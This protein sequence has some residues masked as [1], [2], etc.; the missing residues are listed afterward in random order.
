MPDF[1][2]YTSSDGTVSKYAHEDGSETAIKLPLSVQSVLNPLTRQI[3]VHS[4]DR[5]KFSVFISAS[6]G[7]YM[8]CPFC[9]LTL[10]NARYRPLT[11]DG[12]LANLKEA[13]LHKLQETPELRSKYI[14][15][16]W[17]GMG[18][19]VN[20]PGLVVDVT[21]AFLDWVMENGFAKG[22]DGVDLSTV[23]PPVNPDWVTQFQSLDAMLA[24]YPSNPVHA[25]DNVAYS[26]GEYRRRTPFRLFY[27]VHSA[28]QVG[29]D[30][31]V[32][33][34]LPL[35]LAIPLL[36]QF[37]SGGSHTLVLHHL[38]VDG[39]N[40]SE[41]ELV[42]LA[43]LVNLSFPKQ[44]LRLLRYNFCAKSCYKESETFLRQAQWLSDNVPFLKV[45][46][47]PGAEVSA[48]CGQFIVKLMAKPKARS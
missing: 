10:K 34:A 37:V 17:M 3:D 2:V 19:A 8:R 36:Q 13:L 30:K 42:A 46:V 26:S 48:A 14:K 18:D 24:K 16:S 28:I 20:Q 15:L 39:L 33:G 7:C 44:E 31:T 40:D 21:L 27:S 5:N 12:V 6:V 32:P 23:L 38:L 47:S 43:N 45:Q 1:D 4:S 25:M 22:V 35:V 29:R 9:H 11:S 41:P